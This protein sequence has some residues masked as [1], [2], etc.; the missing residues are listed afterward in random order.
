MIWNRCGPF[1]YCSE[2]N[3]SSMLPGRRCPDPVRI[4]LLGL[5]PGLTAT[6]LSTRAWGLDDLLAA[7]PVILEGANLCGSPRR[8]GPWPCSTPAG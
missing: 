8:S 4:L 3:G 5:A 7:V 1:R 2:S 6:A